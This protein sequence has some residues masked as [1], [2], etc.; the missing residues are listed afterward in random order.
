MEYT[1]QTT[2]EGS[3]CDERC[4]MTPAYI[5]RLAQDV[6]AAHC[7]EL[8]IDRATLLTQGKLFLLAK[9]R[10]TI[11]KTP[12]END[13]LTIT[14]R[15]YAPVRFTY[16]RFTDI[17]SGS[18]ALLARIDSRWI[19]VDASTFRIETGVPS[20]LEGMFPAP[21]EDTAD[22]RVP[23][24]DDYKKLYDLP[25]RYS[26][27]DK[28]GHMNNTVYASVAT[29][30][31]GDLIRSGADISSMTISYHKEARYGTT[32]SIEVSGGNDGSYVRGLLPDG[33]PCFEVS[34]DQ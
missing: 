8:G 32:L 5:L 13:K 21:P 20:F 7:V 15:P 22:F 31:V 14:T 29:D 11:L 2:V 10:L 17:C 9:L 27:I 16:P 4:R 19:L 34:I 12:M 1:I 24:R 23:R 6:S 33:T 30:A 3:L 18:G 25:V 28:N 26:M